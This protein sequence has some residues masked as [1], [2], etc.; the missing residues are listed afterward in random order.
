M[1][2]SSIIMNVIFVGF[3]PIGMVMILSF[4]GLSP[5]IELSDFFFKKPPRLNLLFWLL[6]KQISS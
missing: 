3:A 5:N 4:M 6:N 2:G 1:V